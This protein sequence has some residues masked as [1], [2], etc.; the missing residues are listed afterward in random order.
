MAGISVFG[1]EIKK[2]KVEED[3]GSIISPTPD[4][5]STV[6]NNAAA[7]YGLVI[8]LEGVVKNEVDLIRRYRESAQYADC[9]SAIEDIV[10]E[11][12]V[13]DDTGK[14]V[15]IV[16]DD[17]KLSESIKTKIRDEFDI[18]LGLYKFSEKVM[19][20]LDSGM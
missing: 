15:T 14:T 9:D 1:F 6:V 20:S 5:G 18:I 2:K 4:D 16:L 13:A 12:I 17:V 11:A 8:D 19:T 3:K 10:N 7:H